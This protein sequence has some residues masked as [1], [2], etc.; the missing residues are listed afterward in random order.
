MSEKPVIFISH[1]SEA[2]GDIANCLREQI[3]ALGTLEAY[4]TSHPDT[5]ASGDTWFNDIITHLEIAQ[6]LVVIVSPASK[7]SI[8]VGF[9]IGYFRKKHTEGNL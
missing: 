5:I 2:D 1:V 8:W 9:E 4:A 3:H 7:N 6:A